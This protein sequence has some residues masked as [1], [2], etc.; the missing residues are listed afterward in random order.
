[1]LKQHTHT[2]FRNHHSLK[3]VLKQ[4]LLI[5]LPAVS[6]LMATLYRGVTLEL[7][8]FTH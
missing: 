6:I 8:L 3:V 2:Y 1:M 5:V 7:I 4:E